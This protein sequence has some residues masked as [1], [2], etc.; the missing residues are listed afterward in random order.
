MTVID[1][2]F[3]RLNGATVDPLFSN[4][5]VNGCIVSKKN[6]FS[7]PFGELIPQF[8]TEDIGRRERKPVYF[9]KSGAVKT[10]P[11]QHQ[12]K[13]K[14]PFG[15][16]S[17]ELIT[18]YESG[19]LKRIFPLDGK[20]SGFW[21]WQNESM[22]AEE[23]GLDTPAGYIKAKLLSVQFYE[24]G[25]LKS[26]TL[27]PGQKATISTPYGEKEFR[28]GAAFYENGMLRSFEPQKKTEI[29]TPIGTMVAFDNE[30]NGIHGDLNSLQFDNTG[31]VSGLSTIDNEVSV[32]F[33]GGGRQIFK[34]GVKNNVCGDERKVTVPL[35][36]RFDKGAVHFNNSTPF[37]LDLY[38]FDVR[39]HT[40]KTSMPAYTC[41]G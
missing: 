14:T 17:A 8:E 20:L 11:L 40:R 19:A 1:T 23:S 37:R 16:I 31:L 41:T 33:P 7:T 13:V 35:K 21:S 10:L 38:S 39:K 12:T 2:L 32:Y 18:F 34:P 3:G 4:K 29:P 30:P 15:E 22:L 36:I 28:K 26:L 6:V 25:E 24:Y 5:K 27:W 9:Y